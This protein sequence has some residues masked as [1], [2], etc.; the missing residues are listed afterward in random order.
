MTNI[1]G[2]MWREI[3][4]MIILSILF[5]CIIGYAFWAALKLA[6]RHQKI[7]EIK[8][9]FMNNMTHEFK[10]PLASISLATDAVLHPH[11]IADQ[12]AVQKY[13]KIIKEEKGR[14]NRLVELIL[15]AAAMEKNEVKMNL[16]NVSV[17][18]VVLSV[19]NKVEVIFQDK[20]EFLQHHIKSDVE[21]RG[22][23]RS[24]R[25]CL[26]EL[27]RKQHQILQR[28]STNRDSCFG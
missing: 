10:T 18:Q 5:M 11:V 23:R 26:D 14:L 9:T 4:L 6:I 12:E 16:S 15:Q 17:N 1:Q 22:Q 7:S 24:F 21:V 27:A 19:I 2:D 3:G 8:T 13:L 28:Q 20:I 25:K